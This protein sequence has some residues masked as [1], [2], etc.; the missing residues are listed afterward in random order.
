[1][2]IAHDRVVQSR[3]LL[4]F[5]MN[6]T[7][8]SE[9]VVTVVTFPPHLRRQRIRSEDSQPGKTGDPDF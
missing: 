3:T 7:E 6:I 9:S 1:M 8:V 5:L 4:C 2:E